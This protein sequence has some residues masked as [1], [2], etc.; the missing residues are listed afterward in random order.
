VI[1]VARWLLRV[2]ILIFGGALVLLVVLRHQTRPDR[3][4]S[5]HFR[6]MHLSL[7]GVRFDALLTS[8]TERLDAVTS[9]G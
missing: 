9:A 1:A 6:G 7:G 2:A 8:F 4:R 5:P 3:L